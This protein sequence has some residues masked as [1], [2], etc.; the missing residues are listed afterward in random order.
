MA[1]YSVT[2]NHINSSILYNTYKALSRTYERGVKVDDTLARSVFIRDA[3]MFAINALTRQGKKI[4]KEVH[5]VGRVAVSE[6]RSLCYLIERDS[7]KPKKEA[8]VI[9]AVYETRDGKTHFI[10]IYLDI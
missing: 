10:S 7:S 8:F 6:K 5:K 2:L 9:N 3:L 4:S 1:A